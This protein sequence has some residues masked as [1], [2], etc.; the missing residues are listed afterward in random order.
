MEEDIHA[1]GNQKRARVASYI[2][3]KIVFK[4][5]THKKQRRH[6]IIMKGAIHQEDI[7]TMNIYRPNI[8]TL[9]L[10][11]ANTDRDDERN[12][13]PHHDSRFYHLTF[14]SGQNS[15]QMIKKE[16]EDL[17]NTRLN[18]PN[19]NIQNISL[20]SNRIHSSQ[21]YMEHFPGQITLGYK[22][23]LNKFMKTE[24]ISNILPKLIV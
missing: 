21:M 16:T 12:K 8:R 24:I 7:R 4:S 19:K 23:S 1:K 10:Y 18:G 17:N 5:K 14:S 15:S 13:Q 9:N 11:E 2:S 3:D 22:T 6:Y 20:N